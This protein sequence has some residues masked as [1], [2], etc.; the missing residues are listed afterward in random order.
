MDTHDIEI[1]TLDV[2]H[3]LRPARVIGCRGTK[4]LLDAISIRFEI[5]FLLGIAAQV[6]PDAIEHVITAGRLKLPEA[7]TLP[8]LL[9]CL[10][11]GE[12]GDIERVQLR[13]IAGTIGNIGPPIT[14]RT[15]LSADW[16]KGNRLRPMC[17]E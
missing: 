10:T 9:Q 16:S 7:E 11:T 3:C 14:L 8:V 4:S 12:E 6:T 5:R 13:G 17:R 15:E 1:Q 2:I